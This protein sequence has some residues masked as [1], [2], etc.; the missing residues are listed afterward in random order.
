M[1]SFQPAVCSII[2]KNRLHRQKINNA[3]ILDVMNVH[4]A[5]DKRTCVALMTPH[6]GEATAW[7]EADP[8]LCVNIA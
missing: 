5:S 1:T 6:S 2:A 8:I 7:E 4:V 3:A